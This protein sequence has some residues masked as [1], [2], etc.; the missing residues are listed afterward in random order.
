MFWCYR[1]LVVSLLDVP[2]VAELV[3]TPVFI[4]RRD[5]GLGIT[6]IVLFSCRSFFNNFESGI[7]LIPIDNHDNDNTIFDVVVKNL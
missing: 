5:K 6:V 2:A 4:N 7:I 3:F 1:R